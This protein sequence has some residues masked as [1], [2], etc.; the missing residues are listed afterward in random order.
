MSKTIVWTKQNIF[1]VMAK[2]SLGL[3]PK[4]EGKVKIINLIDSL[5]SRKK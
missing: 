2:D 1:H 5:L 4:S 3:L